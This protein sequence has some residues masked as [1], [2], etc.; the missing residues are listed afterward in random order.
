MN[1]QDET[2]KAL[3]R[4][5]KIINIWIG[6]FGAT[7]SIV[8]IIICVFVWRVYSATQ[9]LKNDVQKFRSSVSESTDIKAQLCD[10]TDQ[11]LI[12]AFARDNSSLCE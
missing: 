8:L 7:V 10:E 4:Q 6:I 9:E 2:A 1:I 12:S 11:G 5:L 3:T